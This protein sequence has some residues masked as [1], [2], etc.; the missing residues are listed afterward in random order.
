MITTQVI[1][2]SLITGGL[3]ALI[4]FGFTLIYNT[5]KFIPFFYGALALWAGY[6]LYIFVLAKI[7]FS[8]SMI[9]SILVLIFLTLILN[10]WLLKS[11]REKKA[12]SVIMLI[13]A[14]ALGILFENLLLAIFGPNVKLIPLPFKNRILN[15][16]GSTLTITQMII[17]FISV[18]FLI[19]SFYILYR[20]K[21][22]LIIRALVSEPLMAEILGVNKE[23]VFRQ[24]FIF[25]GF[26]AAIVGILY[27]IEYNLEPTAGTNLVIK[28]FAASIIGS[29]EFLPA[30]IFGGFFLGFIENLSVLFLPA[31]FKNGITFIILF[32]FLLLK[33][34][35][36]FGGKA[37]EKID[38]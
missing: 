10:S 28:A 33:P 7:P 3:Y 21:Y 37:K 12:S 30:A 4:A 23:N 26:I 32:L 13:L 34:K 20:S 29:L 1:V 9:L 27:G 5:L 6:F 24:V 38:R 25:T 18:P 11:F 31:A 2:N 16:F 19:F 35:G 17:I 14:L 8:I 15:V 36:I 22:G